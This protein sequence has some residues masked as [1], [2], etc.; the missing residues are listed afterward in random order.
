MDHLW[1]PG[2]TDGL[3]MGSTSAGTYQFWSGELDSELV[4]VP[5]WSCDVLGLTN[6]AVGLTS[7]NLSTSCRSCLTFS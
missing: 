7:T 3:L 1:E 5:P 4:F 2:S 6:S